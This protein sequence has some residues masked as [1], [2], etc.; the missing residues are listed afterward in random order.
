MSDAR[1]D[2]AWEEVR[3]RLGPVGSDPSRG[4]AA[5]VLSAASVESVLAR[6]HERLD[7]WHAAGTLKD[8]VRVPAARVREVLLYLAEN[9]ATQGKGLVPEEIRTMAV[10]TTCVQIHDEMQPPPT[11]DPNV[12]RYEPDRDI[13]RVANPENFTLRNTRQPFGYMRY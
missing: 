10:H 9:G 13:Q 7:A 8:R 2:V 6:I 11:W 4:Y 12:Q 5:E 3:S 1:E